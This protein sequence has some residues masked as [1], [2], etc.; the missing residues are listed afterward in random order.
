MN[1]KV[2]IWLVVCNSCDC[3]PLIEGLDKTKNYTVNMVQIS[4][5]LKL[6]SVINKL[7]FKQN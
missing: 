1:L 2:D 3:Y 6:L 7:S 5:K 4:W